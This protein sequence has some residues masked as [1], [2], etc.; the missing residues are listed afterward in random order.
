M[1]GQPEL[2]KS[3]R[4]GK[5]TLGLGIITGKAFWDSALGLNF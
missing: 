2:R 3:V 5:F 4:S 1:E